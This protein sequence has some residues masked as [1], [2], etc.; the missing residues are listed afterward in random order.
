M[1][2]RF[3]GVDLHKR[4]A[5]IDVRDS[6]GKEIRFILSC[7]EFQEY[8]NTLDENDSVI[9][10]SIN[11]AF[12]WADQIEKQGAKCVIVNPHKFKIIKE[13][14]NKTDKRDAKNLSLALWMSELRHEFKL[15]L[16]YKPSV[17]IRDLRKLF[18]MYQM[19]SKQITQH[20]NSIQAV[21]VENGIALNRK[22]TY[23]LFKPNGDITILDEFNIEGASRYCLLAS[24]SII[25]NLLVQKENIKQEIL[26]MGLLF[27][28][29]IKLCISIKG[30][31]PFLVLSFLADVGDITR[32]KNVRGFNAYL[33]VVPTV[34]S[35]GG[36]TQM[37]HI[38]RQSRKLA[39]TMFTQPINHIIASS[40][41]MSEFYDSVKTR[42][43]TGRSRIAVIRKIF[44]IMRRMIL[45][46]EIYRGVEKDKYEKKLKEFDKIIQ[47]VA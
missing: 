38:T 25:W 2:K 34:K 22:Q 43:G 47:K 35:S 36:K 24:L 28:K 16:V 21:F 1:Q 9:L 12:Y 15:P 11:N 27:K 23:R 30:I 41:F 18:S 20:K 29:E 46:G 37:G 4:Y 33:G 44:N 45:T 7:K 19:I 26:K 39:R 13:S 40:D 31:S 32:F 8:I 42:R 17:E 14:W 10:E 3:H 5:T 6:E